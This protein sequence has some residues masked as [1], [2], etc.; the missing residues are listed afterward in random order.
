MFVLGKRTV[1]LVP[2]NSGVLGVHVKR[3]V[4]FHPGTR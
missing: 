3:A 2:E 1:E 4:L